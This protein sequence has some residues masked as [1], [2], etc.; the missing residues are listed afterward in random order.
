MMSGN[1]ENVKLVSQSPRKKQDI[2]LPI[3]RGRKGRDVKV[4]KDLSPNYSRLSSPGPRLTRSVGY[5][6]R[7]N[8]N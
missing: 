1:M 3:T 4:N 2:P 7:T 8:T 5:D 6:G